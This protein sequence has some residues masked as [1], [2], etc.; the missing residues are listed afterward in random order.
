MLRLLVA[1][2]SVGDVRLIQEALRA[3]PI[4]T[5]LTV[6][7]DG[8]QALLRLRSSYFDLVILDLNM[9]KRDGQTI[10]QLCAGGVGAPPFVVF[11]S[12][13]RRSDKELA[14]V[15]GAKEY[16][17]KPTTLRGFVQAIHGILDRWG[18]QAEA[19]CGVE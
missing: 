17:E 4:S 9:P 13:S 12:S 19:G 2:D 3:A 15:A 6:A 11:S 14:L 16:V 8:E 7:V 18:N 10:L 5:D 1:E